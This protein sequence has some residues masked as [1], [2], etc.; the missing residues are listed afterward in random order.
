MSAATRNE[1]EPDRPGRPER[2]GELVDGFLEARGLQEPLDRAGALPAW[3]ETVGPQIARV[4]EP[5]GFDGDT[6][7]VRVASSAWL[8]ELKRLE[9][10]LLRRLNARRRRGRFH[11]IVFT[12]RGTEEPGPGRTSRDSRN[13]DG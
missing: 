9:R 6:L 3:D 12:L 5:A 7:F 13:R 1:R 10:D 2:V 11:R 8:A 4:S